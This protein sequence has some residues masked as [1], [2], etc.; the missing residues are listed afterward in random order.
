[1]GSTATRVVLMVLALGTAG[2]QLACQA[3]QGEVVGVLAYMSHPSLE[4]DQRGFEQALADAGITGVVFDYQN[5]QGETANAYQIARKLLDDR[6]ALVHC[7]ATPACQA[8]AQVI[9]DIP[10]VYS[11]VTDPV[12]AGLVSGLGPDGGNVTG[13]SDAWPIEEQVK[14]YHEMLPAARAWGTVYNPGDANS[15]INVRKAREA[16]AARQMELLVATIASSSDVYTAAQSLAGRVD[17]FFITSDNTVVS[18]LSAVIR[19]AQDAGVPVFAGDTDS[20]PAGAVAALG[21]DYYQVGY[22]AGKRAAEILA[23][24]RPAGEIP[25]G[26]A[27]NFSLHLSLSNAARQGLIVEERFI[28]M[29][30]EGGKVY[31]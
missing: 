5:A 9:H 27:E 26:Y 21:F 11:A 19:V 6:V 7:I 3:P 10:L 24:A 17:A 29:A 22:A 2:S 23:G 4:A 20:V 30:R 14:L 13:V 15:V 28:A 8:A 16:M 25:S 1:M 12:D 31:P 18:A